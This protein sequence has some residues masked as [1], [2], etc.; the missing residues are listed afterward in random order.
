[1]KPKDSILL[2]TPWSNQ[3]H[4]VAAMS[5]QPDAVNQGKLSIHPDLIAAI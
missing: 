5:Q 2:Q 3:A 4:H 1:M